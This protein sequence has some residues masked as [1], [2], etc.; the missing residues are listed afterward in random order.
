MVIAERMLHCRRVADVVDVPIRIH[1][2]EM[3]SP[4]AFKCAYEIHW[5]DGPYTND[6]WG[7]DA[8]QA[9]DLCLKSIAWRL[10]CSDAHRDGTLFWTGQGE[11]YGVPMAKSGRDLLMG[12]DKEFDA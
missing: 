6:A 4:K 9:L 7:A 3:E 10:Y 12:Q 2:P 1:A 11:G 5:P 8:V